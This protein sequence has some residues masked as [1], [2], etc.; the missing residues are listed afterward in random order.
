[1]MAKKRFKAQASNSHCVPFWLKALERSSV[2][3]AEKAMGV[4]QP[5]ILID[6]QYQSNGC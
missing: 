5:D 1:M 6:A 2:P 3:I 4:F